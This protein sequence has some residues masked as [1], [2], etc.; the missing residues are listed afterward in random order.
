M[1]ENII[2]GIKNKS[3]TIAVIGLGYVGLPLAVEKA[4]SGYKTI[5]FDIDKERVKKVNYRESYVSDLDNEKLS[6][7]TNSRRLVATDDFSYINKADFI[8]I[9]VPTPLGKYKQPDL[10][11]VMSATAEV[12]KY[13]KKDAVVVLVSTTYPGTTREL[14]MPILEKT[15]GMKCSKDFYLGFSSERVDPGNKEYNTKN[16]AKVVGGMNEE[17]TRIITS[18][19]EEVID[20]EIVSVSTPEV[21]EMSKLLENIYRNINIGLINEFAI[22]CNK[23]GVNVWEVIEAASSKPY[24]F[25]AFYPGIGVGGHCIPLDP[26]YLLWKIK[27]AGLSISV[28][29]NSIRVNDNMPKYCFERITE[30]LN[31]SELAIKKSKILILGVAYK[32]DI[33]DIRESPAVELIEEL[34]NNG[35]DIKFYDPY[36]NLLRIKNTDIAGEIQLREE[37]ISDCDLVV[38]ATAHKEVNYE[39]VNIYAKK[40]FDIKNV[41]KD[42]KNREN[43]I[44]L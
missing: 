23:I 29:E 39:K 14:I 24:G 28:L 19:Y 36:I 5:G 17:T 32:Q 22:I 25:K 20:A 8:A 11:Y 37:L 2:K 3:I 35:A 26:H 43:I 16:T 13:M 27:E 18:L 21:A 9:C 4:L 30:I 44:L 41:M 33:S 6:R 7:A 31:R 42:I 10:S 1:V 40:I 38:I 34:I 12:G 15:S